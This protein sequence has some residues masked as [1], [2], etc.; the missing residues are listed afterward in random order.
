MSGVVNLK[1]KAT[2]EAGSEPDPGR[3]QRHRPGRTRVPTS[4]S[5]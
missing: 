3:G 2:I 1:P 4:L 5:P